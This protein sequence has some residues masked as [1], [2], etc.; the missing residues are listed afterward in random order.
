[1]DPAL[2]DLRFGFKN[3]EERLFILADI[4]KKVR[5]EGKKI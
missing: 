2:M 5:H 3:S 4:F 1:M